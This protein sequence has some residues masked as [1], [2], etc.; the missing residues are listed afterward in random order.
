M[1]ERMAWSRYFGLGIVHT[2]SDTKDMIVFI[3]PIVHFH[4]QK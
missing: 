1:R 4:T 2:P 3:A